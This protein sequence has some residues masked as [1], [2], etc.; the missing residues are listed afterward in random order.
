MPVCF[1]SWQASVCYIDKLHGF[2]SLGEIEL[3]W[4]EF[5]EHTTSPKWSLLKI[6]ASSIGYGRAYALGGVIHKL[7]KKLDKAV[8]KAIKPV[9]L[10]DAVS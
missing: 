9:H 7:F 8:H 1:L 10:N 5:P 4:D 2:F 6:I 3:N